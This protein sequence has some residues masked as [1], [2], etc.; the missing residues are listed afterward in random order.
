MNGTS[1]LDSLHHVGPDDGT[2]IRTDLW[3]FYTKE[4][5]ARP[6]IKVRIRIQFRA[7]SRRNYRVL[8]TS[9][10]DNK[11]GSDQMPNEAEEAETM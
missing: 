9:G 1:H 3:W 10:D 4:I 7:E 5:H 6:E 2:V 11:A 8:H